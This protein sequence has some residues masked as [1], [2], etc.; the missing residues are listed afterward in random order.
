MS[1]ILNKSSDLPLYVDLDGSLI[2][3][4]SLVES[5]FQLIVKKPLTAFLLPFW[6]FLG[7]AKFKEKISFFVG[8][9]PSHL[10]FNKSLLDYLKQQREQ[11]RKLVLA[12]AANEKI[13]QSIVDHLE[14]FDGFIASDHQ[15]NLSGI[16]KLEKIQELDKDF[17]YVGNGSVD[18][19]IWEKAKEGIVVNAPDGVLEKAKEICN[20]VEV[21]DDRKNLIELIIKQMRMH[22][23][24]KNI[25]VFLPLMLTPH[26]YSLPTLGKAFLAFFG[27]SFMASSVYV[28]N[29]LMDL[30]ADRLHPTKKNRPIASGHL[31]LII[32]LVLYAILL[33]SSIILS[34]L[35]SWKYLVMV[36]GYC[37][38]T[39]FYSI[40][41]KKIVMIDITVLAFLYTW[42]IFCGGIATDIKLSF[43]LLSFS[44]F[45]FTSLAFAKRSA[46]LYFS[47]SHDRAVSRRDY[48]E[49]DLP[50]VNMLGVAF[51]ICSIVVFSLYLNSSHSMNLYKNIEYLWGGSLLLTFWLGRVWIL[52]ARGEMDQDP[53][54]FAVKD[55]I[56][57]FVAFLIL[58]SIVL[59]F[60]A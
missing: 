44:L 29:D 27:F 17:A 47:A 1:T 48:S 4:D 22:Q 40:R 36:F 38:L 31:S 8:L 28:L 45:F 34:F 49:E 58:L 14:I 3:S 9:D 52:T 19:A 43:W 46:E 37:V 15:N 7:K 35:V 20:I 16:K 25:L 13:A 5:I 42:R 51:G 26:L 10:P 39:T 24:S 53:V 56:S 60:L 23:W 30:D 59:S 12:T 18:L 11:G 57:Y 33:F 21:F 41:L 50:I 2:R 32:A 6:L 54:A 55:G